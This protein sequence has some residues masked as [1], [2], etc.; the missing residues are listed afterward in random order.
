MPAFTPHLNLYLPGGG[1]LAIGGDDEALDVDKLNQNFQAIDTWTADTDTDLGT[2]NTFRSDQIS[3]NQQFSGLASAKADVTG[4]KRGD[5]YQETDGTY[6]KFF[7]YNGTAWK[8]RTH[9]EAQLQSGTSPINGT[10]ELP[11]NSASSTFVFEV[12]E[13]FWKSTGEGGNDADILVPYTGLYLLSYT[14]RTN[15]TAPLSIVLLR[16]GV[17]LGAAGQASAFGTGGAASHATRTVSVLL[18]AGDK[19]RVSLTSTAGGSAIHNFYIQYRGE[20]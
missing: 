19:L 5:T 18:T 16:N 2:L 20:I 8:N 13:D 14:S 11:W 12:G 9:A 7:V 15:G 4:M 1:S 6:P 10:I 3:R 17:S